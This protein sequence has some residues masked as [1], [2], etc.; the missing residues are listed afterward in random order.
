MQLSTLRV[1]WRGQ[2][3][4][5]V[6]SPVTEISWWIPVIAKE[7]TQATNSQMLQDR[8][9]YSQFPQEDERDVTKG[10]GWR[11]RVKLKCLPKETVTKHM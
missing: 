1:D 10:G 9:G 2:F 11:D 7:V 6:L 3:G 5:A 4:S 8:K